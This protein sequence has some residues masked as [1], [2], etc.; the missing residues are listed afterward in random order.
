MMR[1][2]AR[3]GKLEL[4][5]FGG[6]FGLM[7]FELVAA[8]L[9]APSIG[10][11][12]YIWTSVIG[13]IIAALSFGYYA[14]GKVADARA[15]QLDLA[16]LHLFVAVAIIFVL[17]ASDLVLDW[18][19]TIF[20]DQRMQGVVAS[21]V[22]FA[23][24]SFLLG[25]LSPY[26]AKLNVTSLKTSGSSVAS[27]S[28][29]NS[30]GGIVGTFAAGFI[31][32]SYIG[33][34]ETLII[35]ATL[36]V[37]LSWITVPQAQ[38]RP[39]TAVSVIIGLMVMIPT[40]AP[41]NVRAV[42]TPSAH[43]SIYESQFNGSPVRVISTGPNVAQSGVNPNDPSKLVFWYTQQIAQIAEVLPQ[44]QNIL[45]LGG[46]AYTLPRY[47]AEKYPDTQIDVAEIDTQLVGL[48]REHFF[49]N[50]PS[51][52]Q[53]ID[54][55]ARAY[56][57][58]TTKRYDLV[59][60]DVY[61]DATVPFTFTTKEY[62]DRLATIV[63]ERGAVAVNMI[64]GTRGVCRELFG[65]L[66]AP[67]RLH[68]PEVTYRIEESSV[69]RSNIVVSYS[70]QPLAWTGEVKPPLASSPLFTDNFSPAERLQQACRN[71]T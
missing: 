43:Y 60:V 26:L 23:P 15:K 67:Y 39:R 52:I 56:I 6:G 66:D 22:L 65:M 4:L 62:G 44:R 19:V 2:L 18:V 3:I 12:T 32:F 25:M 31:L 49:Y 27:L 21:L 35:V 46:G 5:A 37:T 7:V 51:N 13:V 17:L 1:K 38:W 36:M 8:R 9:L 59:V 63:N 70:Y 34:R 24:A 33:S 45:V 11:S 47:L 68:F 29:L 30:V 53:L 20:D 69:V 71:Q 58:Q 57:N 10:S 40:A 16:W 14:G 61:G 64:A 28:A 41:S 55:D 50:D 54:G 48:A 42:D